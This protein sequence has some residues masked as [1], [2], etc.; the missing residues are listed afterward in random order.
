MRRGLRLPSLVLVVA[1]SLAGTAFA[2]ERVPDPPL[3]QKSLTLEPPA[4][5]VGAPSL[6]FEPSPSM[7]YVGTVGGVLYAVEASF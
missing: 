5:I 3:I 4:Q 7:I 2:Q 1:V 6:D